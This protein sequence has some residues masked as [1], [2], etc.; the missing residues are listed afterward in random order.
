MSDNEKH[1][2]AD[3]LVGSRE[4]N[5][6]MALRIATIMAEASQR[7]FKLQSDAANAAFAENS[8]RL[9]ALLHTL[10]AKDSGE[11][12]REWTAL[13]Q[14]NMRGI[15]DVTRSCFEIVPHTQ[16]AISK[17]VGDPI[18]SANRQTQQYL[19]QFT[20]A[21]NDGRDAAAAAAKAFT[22]SVPGGSTEQQSP[23]A[24]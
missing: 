9:T 22:V 10:N 11:L 21:I 23:H 13:Y 12:L 2:A 18:A 5:L 15:L 20:K 14:A 24:T 6:E 7:L 3:P 17:L 4:A 8:G 1:N 19:D 16:A